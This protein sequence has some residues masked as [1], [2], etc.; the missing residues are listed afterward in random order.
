VAAATLLAALFRFAGIGSEGLWHDEAVTFILSDLPRAELMDAF[1]SGEQVPLYPLLLRAW[2][3]IFGITE[4]ALRSLSAV[5][6][7]ATVPALWWAGRRIHSPRA[8]LWAAWA[9]AASPLAIHYSQ[10]LRPY[11]TMMLVLPLA[12]VLVLRIRNGGGWGGVAALAALFS[13]LALSH[14]VGSVLVFCVVAA[15]ML[16]WPGRRAAVRLFLAG[17]LAGLAWGGWTFSSPDPVLRS[18]TRLHVGVQQEGP[19]LPRTLRSL[20]TMTP[21]TDL[22]V[23][24]RVRD[25]PPLAWVALAICGALA[26]LGGLRW[27]KEAPAGARSLLYLTPVLYLAL[28]ALPEIAGAPIWIVGRTDALLLPLALLAVGAGLASIPRA[29]GLA[30]GLCLMALAVPTLRAHYGMDHRSQER[31]LA[32]RLFALTSPDEVVVITGTWHPAL[33]YYSQRVDDP[34]EL[35]TFPRGF[36]N[37]NMNPGWESV[38]GNRSIGEAAR[39]TAAGLET[40]GWP[41]IWFLHHG[42]AIWGPVRE[43]MD[44]RFEGREVFR[45]PPPLPVTVLAYDRAPAQNR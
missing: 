10:E 8:G 3:T 23:R 5:A 9:C 22:P 26:A 38:L 21:G 13:F 18:Q 15:G 27:P 43:A 17:L 33:S 6:G 44:E 14:H 31:I 30:A 42:R 35:R 41:R 2:K 4:G 29:A 34:P 45:A 24:N 39:E 19:L 20:S 36:E 37:R 40:E 28:L 25:V 7:I 1:R 16:P 32:Q 12:I 11:T